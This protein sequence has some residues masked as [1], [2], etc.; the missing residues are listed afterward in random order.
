MAG[1]SRP[2]QSRLCLAPAR[3]PEKCGPQMSGRGVHRSDDRGKS[4]RRVAGYTK[5]PRNLRG[6]PIVR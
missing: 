1:R 5:T 4:W 6:L 2:P 3:K